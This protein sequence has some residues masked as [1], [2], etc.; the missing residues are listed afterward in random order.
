MTDN[1]EHVVKS[2]DQELHHLRTLLTDMG[3]IVETQL[4]LA[5]RAVLNHD[6]TAASSA[7]EADARVDV[8]E[9]D[10]EQFVIRLLALRQPMADDLRHA[11]A[12]L[13]TSA[14]LERIG[15]YATNVS[16]RSLVLNQFTLPF[17]LSAIAHMFQL[18]QENLKTIIDAIGE[19]NADKALLVWHSDQP[20]DDAYNTIFRELIT[21]MMEDPRNITPCTHM[22]FIAKNL[23]RAGDHTTNIAEILYYAV[24]GEVISLP[25]PKGTDSNATLV[26]PLD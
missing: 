5:R 22:L 14:A 6:P 23:E 2:F 1:D 10:V 18:V 26:G 15:D 25:R 19:D 8:L 9:R 16:R 20:V 17:G 12:S 7:M 13:K 21:Y 11:V 3:G 24:R 4:G